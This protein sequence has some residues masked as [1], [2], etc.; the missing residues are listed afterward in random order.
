MTKSGKEAPILQFV[1]KLKSNPVDEFHLLMQ[2]K[3]KLQKKRLLQNMFYIYL[4]SWNTYSFPFVF[5]WNGNRLEQLLAF[6]ASSNT[7]TIFSICHLF[8][9]LV[10]YFLF[11]CVSISNHFLFILASLIIRSFKYQTKNLTEA[12]MD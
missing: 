5:C 12:H 8:C 10:Y 6:I 3:P 4:I 1:S 9:S 2:N 7:I 11:H